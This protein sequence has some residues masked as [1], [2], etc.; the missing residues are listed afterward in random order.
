[1][2]TFG[3]AISIGLAMVGSVI[4]GIA[5]VGGDDIFPVEFCGDIV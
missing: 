5:M 2:V 1:M 4:S 3:G